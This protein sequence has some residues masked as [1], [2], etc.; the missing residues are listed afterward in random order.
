VVVSG[1][2]SVKAVAASRIARADGLAVGRRKLAAR[3]A[4]E[5][6]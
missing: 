6:Q 5:N 3:N 1:D 4:K 2:V